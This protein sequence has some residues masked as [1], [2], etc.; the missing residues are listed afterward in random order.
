MGL[1]VALGVVILIAALRGWLKGF[2]Y[3]VIRLGGLVASF[4]LA[5]PV[6][7][8]VKPYVMPYLAS[9]PPGWM[10]RLIW[11]VSAS[12]N[13]ILIVGVA[14][15][16]MK[17]TRRPEIP[18]VPAQRSRNDQFAGFLLGIA[19]GAVIAS[20]MVAS[21]QK[22]AGKQIET[23]DWARKQAQ[24]SQALAWNEKY[25]P[26]SRIWHSVPVQHF[27]NHIQRMGID[28]PADSAP[29]GHRE[30]PG[31]RPV[32]QTAKRNPAEESG[33]AARRPEASSR[34]PAPPADTS[35]SELQQAIDEIKAA[36][37]EASKPK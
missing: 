34:P 24:S 21:L 14:T 16:A 9:I 12:I 11:W 27:V 10:D 31:D 19:K 25:H 26:A 37:D 15:L 30:D 20:F 18:G 22:F 4:Y 7:D 23:I 35:D 33:K 6:R 5:D 3:Q 32:V 36:L 13:Y 1:D 28:E 8:Q 17:M 2:V 29:Q